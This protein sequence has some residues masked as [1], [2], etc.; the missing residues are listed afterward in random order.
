MEVDR[1]WTVR[2]DGTLSLAGP[3]C[4][5]EVRRVDVDRWTW[6]AEGG[7][8]DAAGSAGSSLEAMR[9]AEGALGL[10]EVGR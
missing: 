8:V 6:W 4:R 2:R 3:G 9:A 7:P 5:A 10:G 1:W